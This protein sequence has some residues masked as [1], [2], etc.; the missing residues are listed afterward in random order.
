[1]EPGNETT[2]A[3]GPNIPLSQCTTNL[4][5][6]AERYPY[7]VS[8][9]FENWAAIFSESTYTLARLSELAFKK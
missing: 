6:T 4:L 1:M 7:L 3:L 8:R 2:K 9:T 5:G